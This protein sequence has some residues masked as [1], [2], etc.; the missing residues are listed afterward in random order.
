MSFAD[1][2]D[3][4]Y[5]GMRIA[6]NSTQRVIDDLPPDMTATEALHKLR[7]AFCTVA[8]LSDLQE[9]TDASSA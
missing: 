2:Q 3:G 7:A 6:A 4:V 5:A 1:Y 9:D 8:L